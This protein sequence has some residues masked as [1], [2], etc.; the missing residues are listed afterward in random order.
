M[1]PGVIKHVTAL[2]A[3]EYFVGQKRRSRNG[4]RSSDVPA[5]FQ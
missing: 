2:L 3:F 4:E 1:L 5:K